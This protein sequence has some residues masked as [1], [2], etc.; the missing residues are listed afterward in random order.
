MHI[1]TPLFFLRIRTYIAVMKNYRAIVV[2][3]F[4]QVHWIGG[5]CAANPYNVRPPATIAKLVNI[6]PI[7]LVYGAYMVLITIATGVY[8]PIYNWGA[9]HC[10][11]HTFHGNLHGFL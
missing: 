8:K 9:S 5:K 2:A 11:F 1:E 3:N 6:T 10:R 7:T 4:H